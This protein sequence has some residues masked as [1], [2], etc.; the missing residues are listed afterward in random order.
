MEEFRGDVQRA[1][2]ITVGLQRDVTRL[3]HLFKKGPRRVWADSYDQGWL[4]APTRLIEFEELAFI[5]GWL[6]ALKDMQVPR[7]SILWYRHEISPS[8]RMPNPFRRDDQWIPIN[9]IPRQ[10]LESN[11]NEVEC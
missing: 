9:A 7:N 8:T 10:L 6:S 3:R 5:R 1:Y 4:D 2:V 11:F